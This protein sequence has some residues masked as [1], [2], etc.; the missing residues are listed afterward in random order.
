MCVLAG[1]STL[2]NFDA[3]YMYTYTYTYAYIHT[4][5]YTHA[6]TYTYIYTY[7]S[8]R[9]IRHMCK[10]LLLTTGQRSITTGFR[11]V[12]FHTIER[13]QGHGCDIVCACNASCSCLATCFDLCHILLI[14]SC[15]KM[16][17]SWG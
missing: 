13:S 2:Y 17:L 4:Y 9:V 3:V 7:L 12:W 16:S 5:I 1:I 15:C 6:Y 14:V 8:I 11:M 10:L